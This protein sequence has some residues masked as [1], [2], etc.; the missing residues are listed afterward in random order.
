MTQTT[1]IKP[2]RAQK[3]ST[4]LADPD[5]VSGFKIFT[6]AGAGLSAAVNFIVLGW[7]MLYGTDTLGLAPAAIGGVIAASQVFN[8]VG[9]LVAAYIV[10]RSPETKLGKARQ[11][12]IAVPFIW[13][14]TFALFATPTGFD[15]TGRLW[16][17]AAMYILINAVFDPLLRA[18]DTL[19]MARAFP[20]RRTYAK[21]QTRA[22]LIQL[23]FILP[24]SVVLPML[25]QRAGKD[26]VQWMIT[27]GLV[28]V[29][30]GVLGMTRFLGVK[31]IYRSVDDNEPPVKVRDMVHALRENRWIWLYSLLPLLAAMLTASA[32]SGYYFR[33]IV[34][35]LGLQGVMAALGFVIL[36]VMLAIPWLMKRFSVSQIVLVSA[37]LG[38]VGNIVSSFALGSLPVL[39]VGGLIA[40][41]APLPVSYTGA[42]F[43]LDLCTYNEWKGN[44]RLESTISSFS[45]IFNKLGAA[46][47]ALIVGFVLQQ[48]GYDGT[49]ATQPASALAAINVLA[50]VLPAGGWLLVV[51]LMWFYGRFDRGILPTIQHEVDARRQALG[52]RPATPMADTDA[53]G[54]IEAGELPVPGLAVGASGLLTDTEPLT[55]EVGLVTGAPT[56]P[57]PRP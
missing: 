11:W 17:I 57:D 43:I 49:L 42:V 9:G 40:A 47:M 48:A 29:A 51:A 20:T 41:V 28:A 37:A 46:A 22:G 2:T 34:G 14:A 54:S 10:D 56:E 39:I 8:A 5:H 44:R 13:V 30:M 27:V 52:L 53:D 16:W 38:I 15:S 45:G 21:V 1:T 19:Y 50:Y 31:E 23:L 26:P 55:N 12:E 24:F 3:R 35:N 18:N 4:R 32:A 6:W 25:L 7:L 36:P 33:Y